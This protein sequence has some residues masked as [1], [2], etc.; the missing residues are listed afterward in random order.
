MAAGDLA[1][2]LIGQPFRSARST[3]RGGTSGAGP[4]LGGDG[5]GRGDRRVVPRHTPRQIR[6]D[7]PGV[8]A[9]AVVALTVASLVAVAGSS[10]TGGA[11]PV[12][13]RG[14]TAPLGDS[15]TDQLAGVLVVLEPS[16]LG[17]RAAALA[18]GVMEELDRIAVP[19]ARGT[20]STLLREVD[21][22]SSVSGGSFA[23]T[24]Y[25]LRGGSTAGLTALK[26]RLLMQ[27]N[28]AA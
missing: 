8:T 7:G 12:N 25:V 9:V 16:G 14:S 15:A 21:Y 22:V 18:V 3:R 11:A 1:H 17:L 24:A 6:I 4:G 27:D 26:D 28:D 5:D 23:A 2:W 20:P 13:V 19:G 10:A